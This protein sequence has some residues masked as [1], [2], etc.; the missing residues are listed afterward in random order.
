MS[1]IAASHSVCGAAGGDATNLPVQIARGVPLA[2]SFAAQLDQCCESFSRHHGLGAG[3]A[4]ALPRKPRDPRE[5]HGRAEDA[6]SGDVTRRTS[7]EHGDRAA[8]GMLYAH[9]A[10]HPRSRRRAEP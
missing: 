7:V 4:A 10:R 5:S 6:A 1:I 8:V 3:S 9:E 2:S